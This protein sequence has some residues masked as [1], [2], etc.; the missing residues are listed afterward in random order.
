VI[1]LDQV[2]I[3]LVGLA[4][5]E[6][7]AA[8]EALAERPRSAVATSATPCSGTLWFSPSQKVRVAVVLEDPRRERA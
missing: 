4:A 8:L 1:V 3:P 6:S 5:Y 2:R 7:V